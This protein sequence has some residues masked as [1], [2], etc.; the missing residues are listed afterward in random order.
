M[1]NV[2]PSSGR[3]TALGKYFAA[4][5]ASLGRHSNNAAPSDELRTA[6]KPSLQ[7][8]RLHILYLLSDLLHHTKY[9][10]DTM[11]SHAHLTSNLQ[12]QLVSILTSAASIENVKGVKHHNILTGLLDLWRENGY[13][14]TDYINKLI[15]VVRNASTSADKRRDLL[16]GATVQNTPKPSTRLMK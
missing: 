5:A 8:K 10:S 15:E 11:A 4:L 2:I 3:I 9:H 16:S 13:Y 14:S 7:R 12:P 6:E 1:K